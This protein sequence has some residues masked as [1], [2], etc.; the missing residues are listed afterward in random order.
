MVNTSIAHLPKITTV[1]DL[2][3]G[4]SYINVEP[5]KEVSSL[6]S[7]VVVNV[8]NKAPPKP[9][10]TFQSKPGTYNQ[11]NSP[12]SASASSTFFSKGSSSSE[13]VQPRNPLISRELLDL[14]IKITGLEDQG[15]HLE[16]KIRDI[17]DRNATTEPMGPTGDDQ[18]KP[19]DD[20]I[21]QLFDLVNEK[22]EMIR[23]QSEVI[24]LEKEKLL[25]EEQ[26]ECDQKVRVFLDK[27][28][29]DKTDVEKVEEARL[30]NKIIEIVK[31]RNEIVNHLEMDRL[32]EIEEDCAILNF[33]VQHVRHY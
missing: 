21:I 17:L 13:N 6:P 20:L 31:E 5:A 1:D 30:I 4:D 25:E 15:V 10:R 9:A 28:E 26:I 32:R 12:N 27:N 22:N 19:E 8:H 7:S 16:K 3:S 11:I 14:E 33:K 24:F 23:K 29:V 18:I 2:P